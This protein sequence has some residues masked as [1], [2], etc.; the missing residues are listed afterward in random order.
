MG[1]DSQPSRQLEMDALVGYLLLSGVLLSM[2]LIVVGL[3][4][5]FANTGRV[6]F[7]YSIKGMNLFQFV[8]NEIR[9]VM[10]GQLSPRVMVSGGIVV[11]MLTPYLRV[12]ASMV[13]FIAALKN[14][15]YSLF[16]AFVLAV[17]TFSLFLR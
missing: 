7:D 4:W 2:G 10:H 16:T 8:V 1:P 9:L 12:L 3:A 6:S 11:L 5:R 13:Y 15:K 14:W 17:L